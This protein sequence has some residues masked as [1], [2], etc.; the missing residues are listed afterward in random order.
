[1]KKMGHQRATYAKVTPSEYVTSIYRCMA[2]L[3]RYVR[4]HP[5]HKNRQVSIN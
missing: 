1:M 5:H 3:S 2:M 4:T